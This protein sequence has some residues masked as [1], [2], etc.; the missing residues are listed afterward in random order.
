MLA[1]QERQKAKGAHECLRRTRLLCKLLQ[2]GAVQAAQ[3]RTAALSSPAAR[4]NA[5]LHSELAGQSLACLQQHQAGLHI[6]P[7][8]T[9]REVRKRPGHTLPADAQCRFGSDAI[10]VVFL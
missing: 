5:A 3:A 9:D 4:N 6:L 10:M 1:Q 8:T 2:R 7:L